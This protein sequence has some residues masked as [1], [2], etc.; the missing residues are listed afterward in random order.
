MVKRGEVVLVHIPYIESAGAGKK[1]P[2]VVVQRDEYNSKLPHTIVAAITS[3]IKNAGDPAV[4]LLD[5]AHSEGK[6]AG[7]LMASLIRC[8]RLFT[9]DQRSIVKSIGHLA[10]GTL[11]R[12]DDCLR[13]SL[14]LPPQAVPQMGNYE[15]WPGFLRLKER[16]EFLIAA[17]RLNGSGRAYMAIQVQPSAKDSAHWVFAD[18]IEMIAPSKKEEFEE[19]GHQGRRALL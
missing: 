12:V 6:S 3:K 17:F 1:R 18:D 10:P 14:G 13:A 16:L 2:V 11:D 19:A 9:I 5:P 8:D 7:V 4:L 15:K